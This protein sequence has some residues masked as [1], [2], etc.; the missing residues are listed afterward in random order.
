MSK[1]HPKVYRLDRVTKYA[2]FAFFWTGITAIITI[3]I[4][5]LIYRV[6]I[7]FSTQCRDGLLG[8]VLRIIVGALLP[9]TLRF[10]FTM[11]V[12]SLYHLVRVTRIK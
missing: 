10:S 2:A 7:D 9:S 6:S 4:V 11:T 1:K 8:P 3:L 5:V 12:A